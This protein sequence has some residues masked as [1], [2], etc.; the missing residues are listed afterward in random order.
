[1]P[2]SKR[3]FPSVCLALAACF[4]LLLPGC[5]KYKQ[6][7]TVMAD[8][9]GKMELVMGMSL[10]ELARLGPE[11]DP[12]AALSVEA[13]AKNPQGFVAFT[14]PRA[15]DVDGYRVVTV[16]GYFEDVNQ[17]AF[18]GGGIGGDQELESVSYTLAESRLTVQRPLAGQAAAA[19]RDEPMSLENP[20]LRRVLAPMLEG[21]ELEESFVVPGAVTSA[22]PLAADGRRATASVAGAEVLDRH[23][24]LLDAFAPLER[25]EIDFEPQALSPSAS[26]AWAR[27]LSD[28]KTDWARLLGAGG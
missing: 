23:D 27:E 4:A 13:L 6:T 28:A 18:A 11:K 17:L 8:G 16:T 15:R 1:M 19:F 2:D 25:L 10:A 14:E 3:R 26:E 21:L 9:S 5:V 12:F 22:G 7:T 24:A 20:E